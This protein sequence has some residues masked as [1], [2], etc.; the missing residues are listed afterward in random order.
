VLKF[1][2]KKSIAKRLTNRI[3]CCELQTF[4]SCTDL[5]DPDTDRMIL[6]KCILKKEVGRV[7]PGL[8]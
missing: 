8:R 4:G 3:Y 7:L 1:E 5:H 2:K 6:L